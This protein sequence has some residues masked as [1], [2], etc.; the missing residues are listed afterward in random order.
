[1]S[2]LLFNSNTALV[3]TVFV[4]N[5]FLNVYFNINRRNTWKKGE[6]GVQRRKV[7]LFEY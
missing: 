5:I 4:T 6:T 2:Q 7:F 3:K 1:M